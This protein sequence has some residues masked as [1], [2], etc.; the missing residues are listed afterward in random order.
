MIHTIITGGQYTDPTLYNGPDIDYCKNCQMEP[1]AEDTHV[2]SDCI[3]HF[4]EMEQTS[5]CCGDTLDIDIKRC[6]CGE[7][8]ESMMDEYCKEHNFNP[9]TYKY[10]EK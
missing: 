2:C 10:G 1:K 3:E 5:L 9:K 6:T 8:S 4:E 7:W